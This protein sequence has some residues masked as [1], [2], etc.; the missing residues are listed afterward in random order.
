MVAGGA[1]DATPVLNGWEMKG[2]EAEWYC[3]SG[4]RGGDLGGLGLG[5]GEASGW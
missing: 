3:V 5:L 2:T 1:F 4:R